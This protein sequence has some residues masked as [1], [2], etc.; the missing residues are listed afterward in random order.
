MVDLIHV[1]GANDVVRDDERLLGAEGRVAA[2]EE[3]EVAVLQEQDDGV[4][5]VG[6]VLGLRLGLGGEGIFAALIRARRDDFLVGTNH[7]QVEFGI[8]GHVGLLERDQVPGLDRRAFLHLRVA[9]RLADDRPAR[10]GGVVVGIR[11]REAL[12]VQGADRHQVRQLREAAEVIDVKVRD[13]DVIDALQARDFRGDLMNALGIA[14]AGVAGVDEHRLAFGRDDERG[15]A[16]LGVHPVNVERFVREAGARGHGE[17]EREQGELGEFIFHGTCGRK[18][19]R[20]VGAGRKIS[21][22]ASVFTFNRAAW[23]RAVSAGARATAATR[24]IAC[25]RPRGSPA[26]RGRRDRARCAARS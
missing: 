6:F 4:G 26:P 25:P 15:A 16:A 14:A 18:L 1:D 24:G 13:D 10:V 2:V 3:A 23:P 5:V 12:V 11:E 17:Q 22:L 21:R 7:A 8:A 20:R 9:V 19:T